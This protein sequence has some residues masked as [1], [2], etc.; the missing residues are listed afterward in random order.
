MSTSIS[1]IF[2]LYFPCHPDRKPNDRREVRLSG[3]IPRICPVPCGIREFSSDNGQ[4]VFGFS[5]TQLPNYPF[6]K[7]RRASPK[8]KGTWPR[9]DPP[10]GSPAV[11]PSR[12][13][14]ARKRET[15]GEAPGVEG[16][17]GG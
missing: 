2:T 10:R 7:F 1:F 5:I 6:T 13:A 15:P 16:K 4:D 14:S 11:L 9:A 17:L 8:P 12:V 3:G